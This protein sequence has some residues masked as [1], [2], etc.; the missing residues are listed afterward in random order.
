MLLHQ[1]SKNLSSAQNGSWQLLVFMDALFVPLADAVGAS[2]DQIK[3][4]Y[5][6]FLALLLS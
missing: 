4:S 3:V 2:V 5:S 1:Q 6:V